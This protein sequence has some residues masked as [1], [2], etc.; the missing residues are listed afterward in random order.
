MT[1][2]VDPDG[3]PHG[4]FDPALQHERT[5]MAWER[6]GIAMM[7]AG[8]L[9]A[10]YAAEDAHLAV[11]V[12]GIIQVMVGAGVMVW[13]GRRYESLHGPLRAGEAVTHPS[14]VRLIGL[15]TVAFTAVALGL[16]V[17]LTLG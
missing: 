11:A 8:L 1:R 6:T 15:T 3:A 12:V 10:R 14:A 2:A 7:V 13:A 16:A 9:L 17:A 5:G 4:V